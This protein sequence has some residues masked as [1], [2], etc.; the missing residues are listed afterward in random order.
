VEKLVIDTLTRLDNSRDGNPRYL[1]KFTNGRMA[2]TAA[3][4]QIGYGIDNSE[5]QGVS[6]DVEF[7]SAGEIVKVKVAD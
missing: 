5:Y 4:S 1:V 3:D 2:K 7:N 6:L